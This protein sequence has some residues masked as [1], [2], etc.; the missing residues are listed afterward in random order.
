MLVNNWPHNWLDELIPQVPK[1]AA[2][3]EPASLNKG[4]ASIAYSSPLG[5][6]A[7]I[8]AVCANSPS[9]DMTPLPQPRRHLGKKPI[10]I[11]SAIRERLRPADPQIAKS[12][13]SP[14]RR[15]LGWAFGPPW[16]P[17]LQGVGGLTVNGKL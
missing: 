1:P 17:L 15:E 8:R 11:D 13:S 2:P 3:A 12:Y 16:L 5:S 7:S 14:P 4:C 10:V 9:K 6:A